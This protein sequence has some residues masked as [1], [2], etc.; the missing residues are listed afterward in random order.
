MGGAKNYCD[1]STAPNKCAMSVPWPTISSVLSRCSF[2]TSNKCFR[3]GSGCRQVVDL[4][5][6]CPLTKPKSDC[7]AVS[8][9]SESGENCVTMA[10]RL[11]LRTEVAAVPFVSKA[12]VSQPQDFSATGAEWRLFPSRAGQRF[13][14][15][16]AAAIGRQPAASP[17]FAVGCSVLR[18]STGLLH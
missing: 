4:Q 13:Q 5:L 9:S 7:S 11:L 2:S 15:R 14:N 8:R 6:P 18:P 12:A 16:G 3:T 17:A 1:G 10:H